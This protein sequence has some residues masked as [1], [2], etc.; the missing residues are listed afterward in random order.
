MPSPTPFENFKAKVDKL[1]GQSLSETPQ[2]SDEISFED[3]V[4]QLSVETFGPTP[5]E[6]TVPDEFSQEQTFE[7]DPYG[8]SAVK[9]LEESW[10]FGAKLPRPEDLTGLPGSAMPAT[11][12]IAPEKPLEDV[13]LPEPAAPAVAAPKQQI[14]AVVSPISIAPDLKAEFEQQEAQKVSAEIE[15]E[16]SLA[17]VKEPVAALKTF[18]Q[19]PRINIL[20]NALKRLEGGT[21]RYTKEYQDKIYNALAGSILDESLRDN[22]PLDAEITKSKAENI[23]G[24][25][26]AIDKTATDR[27]SLSLQKGGMR[28]AAP[29]KAQQFFAGIEGSMEFSKEEY[30]EYALQKLSME[31]GLDFNKLNKKLLENRKRQEE[32]S[33]FDPTVDSRYVEGQVRN[34][35]VDVLNMPLGLAALAVGGAE[36]AASTQHTGI[37]GELLDPASKAYKNTED[38]QEHRNLLRDG[39]L[40]TITSAEE[41][42]LA[43]EKP[44][45]KL[46]ALAR[47]SIRGPR[48][49][50]EGTSVYIPKALPTDVAA[51]ERDFPNWRMDSLPIV[52]QNIES[53][54][55]NKLLEVPVAPATPFEPMGVATTEEKAETILDML[56]GAMFTEDVEAA[57][58]KFA[59]LVK[60]VPLPTSG[61]TLGN[62][63][64]G[65]LTQAMDW[66]DAVETSEYAGGLGFITEDRDKIPKIKKAFSEVFT[67]DK[68]NPIPKSEVLL[69]GEEKVES[70]LSDYATKK[71]IEDSE[72]K[73]KNGYFGKAYYPDTGSEELKGFKLKAGSAL[74][75]SSYLESLPQFNKTKEE[76][77]KH[78]LDG[79]S[80]IP[81]DMLLSFIAVDI[82]LRGV[83]EKDN[84][85]TAGQIAAAKEKLDKDL[86]YVIMDL[87]GVSSLIGSLGKGAIIG[88]RAARATPAAFKGRKKTSGAMS[89]DE[90]T[91]L[92]MPARAKELGYTSDSFKMMPD[93]RVMVGGSILQ[94]M[95]LVMDVLRTTK[96]QIS[97]QRQKIAAAS[98]RAPSR[99]DVQAFKGNDS[100]ALGVTQKTES[101]ILDLETK[102]NSLKT[103]IAE[104]SK[105]PD[106][107]EAEIAKKEK[108]LEVVENELSVREDFL[109]NQFKNLSS[110]PTKQEPGSPTTSIRD[111]SVDYKD[112]KSA[113]KR[114][115][116]SVKNYNEL[117]GK[118]TKVERGRAIKSSAAALSRLM[119]NNLPGIKDWRNPAN[120]A[121]VVSMLQ[122]SNVV[123]PGIYRYFLR[124]TRDKIQVTDDFIATLIAETK[125]SMFKKGKNLVKDSVS[126]LTSKEDLAKMS[127]Q[128]MQEFMTREQAI[129]VADDFAT[130]EITNEFAYARLPFITDE[131][132]RYFIKQAESKKTPRDKK[133]IIIQRNDDNGLIDSN[134]EIYGKRSTVDPRAN[135]PVGIIKSRFQGIFAGAKPGTKGFALGDTVAGDVAKRWFFGDR[136]VALAANKE[137]AYSF[138]EFMSSPL[139]F[140]N[141]P[142]ATQ[143]FVSESLLYLNTTGKGQGFAATFLDN[144]VTPENRIGTPAYYNLLSISADKQIDQ[145]QMQRLVSKIP[146]YGDFVV[147]RKRALEVLDLTKDDLLDFAKIN[148]TDFDNVVQSMLTKDPVSIAV[149]GEKIIV[150]QFLDLQ[151]NQTKKLQKD[152]SKLTKRLSSTNLKSDTPIY[153]KLDRR[154]KQI[155]EK[156]DAGDVYVSVD[157]L[158]GN[159]PEKR[160]QLKELNALIQTRPANMQTL[161]MQ[162]EMLKSDIMDLTAITPEEAISGVTDLKWVPKK[163][164]RDMTPTEK[165]VYYAAREIVT[166]IEQKIY[167]VGAQIMTAADTV[168]L[169]QKNSVAP[170][171]IVVRTTDDGLVAVKTFDNSG[172]GAAVAFDYT[173]NLNA[174]AQKTDTTRLIASISPNLDDVARAKQVKKIKK[175]RPAEVYEVVSADEVVWGK[176]ASGTPIIKR[177]MDIPA[178]NLVPMLSRYLS[179]YVD[180]GAVAMAAREMFEHS[181]SLSPAAQR[182]LQNSMARRMLYGFENGTGLV[183]KYGNPSKALQALLDMTDAEQGTAL[184]RAF[185]PQE[186]FYA[187]QAMGSASTP[188]ELLSLTTNARFR[189]K[190]TYTGLLTNLENYRMLN[191]SRMEGGVLTKS[192]WGL[193]NKQKKARYIP[194]SNVYARTP[195]SA[196]ISDSFDFIKN[197]DSLKAATIGDTKLQSLFGEGQNLYISRE[198]ATTF[199]DMAGLVELSTRTGAQALSYYKQAKILSFSSGIMPI[200]MLSSI[201]YHGALLSKRP[202][203]LFNTWTFKNGPSIFADV[204]RV[205]SGRKAKNPLVEKVMRKGTGTTGS[206]LEFSPE[207]I[208]ESLF[209]VQALS[210]GEDFVRNPSSANALE[211]LANKIHDLHVNAP[212]AA[213]KFVEEFK[214]VFDKSAGKPVAD[215]G[216]KLSL[217]SIKANASGALKT[218]TGISQF[219]YSVLDDFLK[220]LYAVSLHSKAKVPIGTAVEEAVKVWF[221]YGD[222]SRTANAMRYGTYS[223][224]A[225]PFIGYL[226][227]AAYSFPSVFANAPLRAAAAGHAGMVHN[228]SALETIRV[229][230][231]INEMRVSLGDPLAVPFPF[232]DVLV[233][234]MSD[235][236]GPGD[237]EIEDLVRGG[238]GAASLKRIEPS[239]GTAHGISMIFKDPDS[240]DFV[241]HIADGM[242]TSPAFDALSKGAEAA[243]Y[244]WDRTAEFLTDEPQQTGKSAAETEFLAEK[245]SVETTIENIE[246]KSGE[247]TEK[248]KKYISEMNQYISDIVRNDFGVPL[249]KNLRSTVLP[250]Q[251]ADLWEMLPETKFPGIAPDRDSTDVRPWLG[252]RYN[253][254]DMTKLQKA[255]VVTK[256]TVTILSDR[257]KALDRA[258][259]SGTLSSEVINEN[260]AAILNLWKE[261]DDQYNAPDKGKK[262]EAAQIEAANNVR[263]A[264]FSLYIAGEFDIFL[265]ERTRKIS[266]Q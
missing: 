33:S 42:L 251:I 245:A 62:N 198:H 244:L 181:K 232:T 56:Q 230:N 85:Y 12:P 120:A 170:K 116:Q 177:A 250:V 123:D 154:R 45:T 22:R 261:I 51:I 7:K 208:N 160:L 59:P 133:K 94:A 233:G 17:P 126:K 196:F 256:K 20:L 167:N 128:T 109:N 132:I 64:A 226:A 224:F 231:D 40:L 57:M 215:S 69:Y 179:V 140:V 237:E 147:N 205:K 139:A 14:G 238:Q 44:L 220:T 171:N 162:R 90:A 91:K 248:E 243:G 79:F 234:G 148:A 58:G 68:G 249:Y 199:S 260:K 138:F 38:I 76:Y 156:I 131:E 263:A 100:T 141:I 163:S 80:G 258:N 122:S 95:D 11:P 73:I 18:S 25:S 75:V 13:A 119:K 185:L 87:A 19:S 36:A 37:S 110:R 41:M 34:I 180:S 236:Y 172:E 152:I 222:L 115:L 107:N 78:L 151:V 63:V 97:V 50:I 212:N 137:Y 136:A 121:Q 10:F 113:H 134:L 4:D 183:E 153:R 161:L 117:L 207:S 135:P 129:K 174:K 142:R 143:N 246:N 124:N 158:Y 130:K 264:L 227:N 166:P 105:K 114:E 55:T 241:S 35:A 155:Q 52:M 176:D 214:V 173:R 23:Q 86:A 2:V 191:A 77:T 8:K 43:G 240:P 189:I 112:V 216:S 187:S 53:S 235:R 259:D 32:E 98:V 5:L 108:E 16:I 82:A 29:T 209:L 104:S 24:F 28:Q 210:L 228:S 197:K 157:E 165:T 253:V 71:L 239:P 127:N 60:G 229:F 83:T 47:V 84:I 218:A 221:N 186:R 247:I 217:G 1:S 61:N 99:E 145:L 182:Q 88:A 266:E 175:E 92:M 204:V 30:Q 206:Y 225:S 46:S 252:Y 70:F 111:Q 195:G 159:L 26:Q 66:L 54:A 211:T 202:G 89:M 3:R 27:P 169:A 265:R 213:V 72:E 81:E 194:L 118:A 65:T 15:P 67:D 203:A 201:F 48:N 96:D 193:L 257:I 102:Q 188:A 101:S 144:F 168:I 254:A 150:S 190:Q 192:Q 262:L 103:E 6:A 255:N 106:R 9:E 242:V 223:P 146:K 149:N 31:Q 184:G 39:D 178:T 49:T 21:D 74:L 93:G 219:S 125:V 164:F 200:Q